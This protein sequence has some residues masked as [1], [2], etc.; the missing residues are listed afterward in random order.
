MAKNRVVVD[1]TAISVLAANYGLDQVQTQL[2]TKLANSFHNDTDA[3][4]HRQLK[5]FNDPEVSRALAAYTKA[6]SPHDDL[7]DELTPIYNL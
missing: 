6:N 3:E 2:L 5:S 4:F 1:A 7:D